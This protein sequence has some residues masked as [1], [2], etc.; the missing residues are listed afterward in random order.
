MTLD[1]AISVILLVIAA[2]T[3][4]YLFVALVDPERF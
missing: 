2:A 3:I 4:V 1:G